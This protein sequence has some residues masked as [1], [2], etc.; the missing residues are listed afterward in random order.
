MPQNVMPVFDHVGMKQ[1]N[2]VVSDNYKVNNIEEDL[3]SLQYTA[4]ILNTRL[5][6]KHLNN[7]TRLLYPPTDW[8][9]YRNLSCMVC[10]V[11]WY[12]LIVI[13]LIKE[14]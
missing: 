2:F 12:G 3:Y 7:S 4:V 6:A 1:F 5:L 11:L 13:S 14:V 8:T 10:Y 9:A